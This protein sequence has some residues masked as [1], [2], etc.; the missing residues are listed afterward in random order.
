MTCFHFIHFY[1]YEASGPI[2]STAYS[3]YVC[4]WNFKLHQ[5]HVSLMNDKDC[6]EIPRCYVEIF[7]VQIIIRSRKC[8]NCGRP[9]KPHGTAD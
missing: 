3:A 8:F 9:L 2:T 5:E 6:V 4:K 1:D 7:C